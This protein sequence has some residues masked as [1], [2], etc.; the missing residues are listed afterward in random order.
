M[1]AKNA[2]L[3]R[4]LMGGLV[5]ASMFASQAHADVDALVI[6]ARTLLERGQAQQAYALL[7]AQE[8]PRAG[9]PDFDTVLGIAA[10]ETGLFTQAVFALERALAVQPE[11]SRARAELGRALFSVGDI[12][13]S[14]KVLMEVKRENIPQ[15]AADSIDQFLRAIDRTE[16]AARSSI[17][18][19]LEAT[20]G[21]DTNINSGP[22]NP[23]IAVPLFGGAVF[24]LSPA[25]VRT[26]D[27]YLTLGGGLSGRYVLDPRWSLIGN[28]SGNGRIN[29]KFN[30]FNTSQLDINGGASYRFEKNEFSGVAQVG[31]STVNGSRARDQAG[32]VGEWTYR[33]DGFQQWTSYLQWSRLSY[34]SQ[35][36][37][38]A[39]R[40]VVGTSYAYAFRDGLLMFA[41][42]YVGSEKERAAGVPHLGNKLYG[43]RI[44][45][46]KSMRE[47]LSVFGSLSYEDREYGGADPLFLVTRQDQQ[48]NFN[49]GLNW[50]PGKFWRVTPQL[51]LTSV[52][53]NVAVSDFNKSVLSVTVRRDF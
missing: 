16:E 8:T 26:T 34:S 38:D 13:A 3:S 27:S 28:V 5:V 35:S 48:L 1:F 49:M 30:E 4:G 39:N 44:G 43:L 2:F 24:T 41:G 22:G 52:K 6:E 14:R 11:N 37:R 45:S 53:S 47:E 10:N 7:A 33:P 20:F 51:S 12:R 21:Y 17:K 36:V 40:T 23:N 31:T 42:G 15:G 18:P 19:Y 50:V 29:A 25:G 46:Q 32:L 9:D